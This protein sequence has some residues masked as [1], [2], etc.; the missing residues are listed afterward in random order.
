M[1]IKIAVSTFWNEDVLPTWYI[2]IKWNIEINGSTR[3]QTS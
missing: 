1:Q 2:D 3:D